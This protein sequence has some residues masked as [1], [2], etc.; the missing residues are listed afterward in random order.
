MY[1]VNCLREHTPRLLTTL[2]EV[3]QNPEFADYELQEVTQ[4]YASVLSDI[5]NQ[6]EVQLK[7]G[8]HAAAYYNNTL[9]LP[10]YSTEHGVEKFD[11]KLLSGYFK[12]FFIPQ[13]MVVCGVGVDHGELVNLSKKLF[14]APRGKDPNVQAAHYTGGDVRVSNP[15]QPVVHV[16][17]A[18]EGPSWKS[19]DVFAMCVLQFMLGGGGAFSAG[20]PGK[21]MCSRLYD[22][23]NHHDW[24]QN[25]QS[26]DSIF[27]DS[28][29]FGITA[30]CGS[31]HGA[32]AVDVLVE[33]FTKLTK[34][35]T[36]ELDRAKAQLK[37]SLLGQ[38]ECRAMDFED[39]GRQLLTYNKVHGAEELCASI[40]AVSVAD[41]E[42]VAGAMLKR[43]PAFTA[44]GDL[45][46]VPR[47]DEI[48]KRFA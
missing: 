36:E 18:F 5:V 7:E 4:K 27:T 26:Y 25:L 31:D 39:M 28:A 3:T 6:P 33:N 1:M 48:A 2:A 22:V 24:V 23:L 37:T 9:G 15:D 20:G 38:L 11:E 41:A 40:D 43:K 47:Y 17:L 45:H 35:Q 10:F 32:Q 44:Y 16:S 34:I 12:E 13:R 14:T 8:I 29:L 30:E 42:R 21:G 46:R 19:K